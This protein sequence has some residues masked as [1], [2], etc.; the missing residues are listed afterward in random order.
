[1]HTTPLPCTLKMKVEGQKKV[2]ASIARHLPASLRVNEGRSA[3]A[4][5]L[6]TCW[7]RAIR[8]GATVCWNSWTNAHNAL[9]THAWSHVTYM[10]VHMSIILQS[11]PERVLVVFTSLFRSCK[12][13]QLFSYHIIVLPSTITHQI[14][15]NCHSNTAAPQHSMEGSAQ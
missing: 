7:T 6:W 10:T 9:S 12:G 1:M 5:V 2:E 8:W 15:P 3:V 13:S 14:L 4:S 11:H